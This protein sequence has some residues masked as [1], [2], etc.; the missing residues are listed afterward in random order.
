MWEALCYSKCKTKTRIWFSNLETEQE[1]LKFG[2]NNGGIK[3]ENCDYEDNLDDD[4]ENED[5]TKS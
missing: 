3:E 1:T 5:D 4:Y 2:R